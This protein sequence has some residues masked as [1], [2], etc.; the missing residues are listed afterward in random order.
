MRRC[1]TSGSASDDSATPADGFAPGLDEVAGGGVEVWVADGAGLRL[2]SV[3]SGC[4]AGVGA[5]AVAFAEAGSGAGVPVRGADAAGA[6]AA[7]AEAL[8]AFVFFQLRYPAE[9]ASRTTAA[10]MMSALVLP[11]PSSPSS[12][13]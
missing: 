5:E 8:D 6:V 2:M 10:T 3:V 12:A 11:P 9:H 7:A 4:A 1:V 13:S